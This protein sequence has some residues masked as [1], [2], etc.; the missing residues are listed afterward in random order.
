[1]NARSGTITANILFYLIP[2]PWIG[3]YG[4]SVTVMRATICSPG[5]RPLLFLWLAI[6]KT[7]SINSQLS[8]HGHLGYTFT[9]LFPTK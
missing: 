1:V 9:V 2:K 8:P 6:F 5:G 7:G 4:G 3:F